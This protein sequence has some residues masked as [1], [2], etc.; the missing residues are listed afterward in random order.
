MTKNPTSSPPAVDDRQ[1]PCLAEQALGSSMPNTCPA[2]VDALRPAECHSG[3]RDAVLR[4]QAGAETRHRDPH[5]ASGRGR[6]T[7]TPTPVRRWPSRRTTPVHP[8]TTPAI[9]KDQNGRHPAI[10][11]LSAATVCAA[12]NVPSTNRRNDRIVSAKWWR[13]SQHQRVVFMSLL[14]CP[15]GGVVR[16]C[17]AFTATAATASGTRC[18][19]AAPDE[20]GL[21]GGRSSV[22]PDSRPARP[23][24]HFIVCS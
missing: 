1:L 7:T 12:T 15:S 21:I 19:G 6:S 2:A 5:G 8:A 17:S 9:T 3:G 4:Q 13:R 11:F 10:E 22:R 18:F 16:R 23:R 20:I 14:S 24:G